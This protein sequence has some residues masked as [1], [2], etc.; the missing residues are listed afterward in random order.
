VGAVAHTVVLVVV[1]APGTVVLVVVVEPGTVV[2][3]A[4]VAV[5]VAPVVP[6]VVVVVV[7]AGT[8]KVVVVLVVVVESAVTVQQGLSLLPGPSA[9]D[10]VGPL[11]LSQIARTLIEDGEP[12]QRGGKLI[13]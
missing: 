10:G 11:E 7:E 1:V 5:V 4:L 3:V 13:L 8:A 12:M 9:T 2:L 6:V